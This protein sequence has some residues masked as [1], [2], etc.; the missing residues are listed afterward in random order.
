[1]DRNH[2]LEHHPALDILRDALKREARLQFVVSALLLF[3]SVLLILCFFEQIPILGVL[4]LAL[5]IWSIKLLVSIRFHPDKTQIMRL[6]RY[7]PADIV[8]VY[9]IVTARMPYGFHFGNSGI[10]YFKLTNGDELSVGMSAQHL[11][12]VSKTLNRLLPRAVFGY[13]KKREE[14]FK[15]DPKALRTNPNS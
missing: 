14:Q 2:L 9:G 8:W 1:M 15:K 10:L 3:G 13:T 11:K 12:L 5:L 7:R 4:C 6:I